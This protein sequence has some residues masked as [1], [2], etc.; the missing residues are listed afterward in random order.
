MLFGDEASFAQWGSLGYTWAPKG[1]Q[2]LVKTTGQRK[3]YKVFGLS[4][5]FSG[6]LFWQG[7][8]A[9]FTSASYCAFL[10]EVLAATTQPIFLIQDVACYPTSA[11][12]RAFFAAHAARVPVF[13]LPTY[14]PDYNP[15]EHLWRNVKRARTHNRYVATFADLSAAVGDARAT[16]VHV[17]AAVKQLLGSHLDETLHLPL[18]A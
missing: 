10:S 18:A 14:S 15:I 3:A 12:T 13:Q 11:A 4:A 8:S 17:P 5:Y 9:R 7:H 2:P 6:R 16:F 1:S